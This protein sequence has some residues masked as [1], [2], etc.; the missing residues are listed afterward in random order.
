MKKSLGLIRVLGG[1]FKRYRVK[2]IG[3]EIY[4]VNFFREIG[5]YK[6]VCL[7]V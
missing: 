7:F 5:M 6:I 1:L 3:F 4:I 2:V